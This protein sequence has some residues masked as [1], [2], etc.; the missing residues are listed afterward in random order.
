[1]I[2]PHAL[3]AAV[4][5]VA[6]VP[7]AVP[8]SGAHPAQT[9]TA[10]VPQE[11][12]DDFSYTGPADPAFAGFG[13]TARTGGGGPGV[14]GA[15]WSADN[16]S[17]VGSGADRVMRL[18]ATSQGT[19][20]TTTQASVAQGQRFFEGTYA[21]RI[22]FTDAPESGPDGDQV[23]QTFYTISQ[24]NHPLDPNYSELDYEYVPNGGLGS[25]GTALQMVTW[26]TYQDSPWDPRALETV[27]SRSHDGWHLLK[28]DV[29]GGEVRYYIDGVLVASHGGDYAP[30]AFM[31]LKYAVWF[32]N[33]GLVSS[34]TSRRYVLDVDWVYH[35]RDSSLTTTEVQSAVAGFRAGGIP[36]RD[37][38]VPRTVVA[39]DAH[40]RSGTYADTNFG[41]ATAL[42][43]KDAPNA[44]D[45]NVDRLTYLKAG[46]PG[47]PASSARLHLHVSSVAPGAGPVP[48]AVR[49]LTDDSWSE[50]TIT[51]NNRPTAG[52]TLLGT[53]QVTAPGWY[54]IDVTSAV[55]SN[56]NDGQISFRL[57]DDSVADRLV[58]IDSREY[59]AG[60]EPYLLIS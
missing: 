4:L 22:R 37:T 50:S 12:F 40:V 2:L 5:A 24:L 16:V 8:P 39:A 31:F 36:R 58:V 11:F 21:T 41:P 6:S 44:A 38:L 13:W 17:M 10:A 9:R 55:N 42:E 57:G 54:A 14:S 52:A 33:G 35:A 47:V 48:I 51:W 15:T 43:V 32:A 45:P 1:M 60:T 53:L 23:V 34:S 29:T 49:V 27:L 30:E 25:A 56:L 28:L 7:P 20:Q 46:L 59:G 26:E 3:L 18:A 19:G